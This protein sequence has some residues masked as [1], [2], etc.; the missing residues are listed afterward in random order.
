[1]TVL[2]A[3]REQLMKGAS[4]IK[5]MAGGGI[6]SPYDPIDVTQYSEEEIRLQSV[7]PPTGAP[8]LLSTPIPLAPCSAPSPPGCSASNTG[9]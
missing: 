8:T 6:A 3:T 5:V 9:N 1:M 7:P 2:R 4:Q